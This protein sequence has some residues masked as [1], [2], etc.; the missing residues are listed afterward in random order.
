MA[1]NMTAEQMMGYLYELPEQFKNSLALDIDLPEKYQR[2]YANILVTGLGGSAI[3]GDI[4]KDY[5]A[6]KASLPILVNRDY[7]IPAFVGPDTLFFAVSYSG[8]TEETLSAYQEAVKK[9][10]VII[11]ITSGGKL[12][13]LANQDGNYVIKV[14]GGLVPRAATGYLFAPLALA[15]EKLGFISG[16][17][18]ELE[19]TVEVLQDIRARI[20]PNLDRAEN[21]AKLIAAQLQGSLPIVWGASGLSETAALRWKAQLNENAKCMAYYNVF[22]ELNHNEIVGFEMP[23]EMVANI[24]VIILKDQFDN[25]KI[26]KRM[27]VTT[28]IIKDKVKNVIEVNSEGK[29]FLARFYS[30]TYIGDY[31]SV[32]LALD[33]GINPTPVEVIDY[34]KEQLA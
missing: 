21:Q 25:E 24:S 28:D 5:A 29:S 2:S 12:A 7:N 8:N 10:A 14:P 32:Y 11:C 17:G 20:N 22:P 13:E 31:A 1:N 18:A 9:G 4:L 23:E 19:E 6:S 26:K 34:L 16:I 3:G 30:L 15:V 27:T 33:Y